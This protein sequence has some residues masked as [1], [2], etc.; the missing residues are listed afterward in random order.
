MRFSES[1]PPPFGML[2]QVFLAHFQPMVT[3]FGPWK[4][5]KCFEI[6]PFGDQKRVKNGSKTCF[7]KSDL[8]P[9]GILK[10]VF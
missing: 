10:Q 6:A 3:R 4:I 7:P 8:E 1:H 2:K 9:F 5:A